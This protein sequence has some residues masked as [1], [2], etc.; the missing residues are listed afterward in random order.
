M[1]AL[2]QG[3]ESQRVN[4]FLLPNGPGSETDRATEFSSSAA[5][6]PARV[7]LSLWAEVEQTAVSLV[8]A[9]VNMFNHRPRSLSGAFLGEIPWKKSLSL[10]HVPYCVAMGLSSES[11]EVLGKLVKAAPQGHH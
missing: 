9:S 6:P 2:P 7:A 1:Q 10:S 8:V 4:L 3:G 11:Q 5:Q